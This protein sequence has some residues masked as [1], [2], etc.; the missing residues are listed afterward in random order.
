MSPVDINPKAT[1]QE[2]GTSL[3]VGV[4]KDAS[5]QK[6]NGLATSENSVGSNKMPASQANV[7]PRPESQSQENLSIVVPQVCISTFLYIL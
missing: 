4:E 7:L 1:D 2:G 3:S 6:S 5:F